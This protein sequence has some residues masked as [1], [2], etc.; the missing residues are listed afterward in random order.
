LAIIYNN[1][2]LA[3]IF[4]GFMFAVLGL[5]VT[6]QIN[7]SQIAPEYWLVFGVAIYCDWKCREL[8]KSRLRLIR[9]GLA[10]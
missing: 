7:G 6:G 2:F 4:E 9:V 5:L 8:T 10:Q 3:R 1:D